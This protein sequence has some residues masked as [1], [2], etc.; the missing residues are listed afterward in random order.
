MTESL[1]TTVILKHCGYAIAGIT[2]ALTM[3][4]I[5]PV[6]AQAL[7]IIM[8]FDTLTGMIK[9]VI[10]HGRKEFKSMKL[11]SGAVTKLLIWCVP[12]V[13]ATAARGSG[14][15]FSVIIS[16]SFAIL[17]FGETVSIL[18]NIHSISK[19][20]DTAE[21]DAMSLIYG[22]FRGFIERYLEAIKNQKR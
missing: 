4:G 10:V 3:I 14:V 9:A 22:I 7:G 15:D 16:S 12:L 13:F 21:F 17:I 11:I 20:R 5:D 6:A 8:I 2:G 18:G 1:S 19:K